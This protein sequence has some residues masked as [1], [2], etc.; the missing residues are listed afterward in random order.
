MAP[1]P[2][3]VDGAWISREGG[4]EVTFYVP[5]GRKWRVKELIEGYAKSLGITG[6]VEFLL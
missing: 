5:P 1:N 6:S 3:F 4:M 2:V